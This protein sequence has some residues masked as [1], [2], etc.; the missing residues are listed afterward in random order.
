VTRLQELD[1]PL[2]VD[3]PVEVETPGSSNAP[4][5]DADS[6]RAK[7]IMTAILFKL[8]ENSHH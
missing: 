8:I 7:M 2:W 3:H 6:D 4:I 1:A 5:D